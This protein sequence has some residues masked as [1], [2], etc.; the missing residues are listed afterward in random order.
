MSD[1]SRMSTFVPPA[2]VSVEKALF[3]EMQAE[4]E[5]LRARVVEL[6]AE[7]LRLL[8]RSAHLID[9]EAAE[10]MQRGTLEEPQGP[11]AFGI[12]QD[13]PPNTPR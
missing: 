10:A 1:E 6:E 11:E 3:L 9:R 13:V 5:R 8:R 2:Y 12:I 7:Q 4:I